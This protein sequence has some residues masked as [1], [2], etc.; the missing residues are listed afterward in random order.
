MKNRTVYQSVLIQGYVL[1]VSNVYSRINNNQNETVRVSGRHVIAHL[2]QPP[3]RRIN[4]YT[5]T[6]LD[7]CSS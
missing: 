7:M 1:S 4:V 5:T 3:Q 6:Q 2:Q